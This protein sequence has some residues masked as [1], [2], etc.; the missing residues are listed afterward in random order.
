MPHGHCYLWVAGLIRLHLLTDLAIGLAYIAISC[1]LAYLVSKAKKDI[2]FSWMFLCFGL[3]IIACGAT[4]LMEIW[5]LWVPLY[6]LSGIVK[7]VTALAS[8][9][10]AIV[11]PP[12]VPK[13]LEMIRSAKLS[14]RR[15]AELE[16]AN[17]ALQNE[18]G[19]RKRAESETR[20]LNAQLEARVDARTAELS[21]ANL[22]LAGLAAIVESS[23]DAIVSLDEDHQITTWNPAAERIYGFRRNEVLG[24]PASLLAPAT[25]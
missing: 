1:T 24:R 9:A 17:A 25:T 13:S 12:L 8:V 21:A 4:H 11:L 15:Y 18:I 14:D 23:N 20:E 10:T 7:L 5:T 16:Q 6:W 22:A 19:E 3:F 2:P